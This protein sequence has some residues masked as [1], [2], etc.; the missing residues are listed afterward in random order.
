MRRI[1]SI[2]DLADGIL[3]HRE[4]MRSEQMRFGDVAPLNRLALAKAISLAESTRPDDQQAAQT[5]LELLL[6]HTGAARRIGITGVPGVGK[7]TFIEALGMILIERG[8]SLATLA[9]DPS[10]TRSGGSILGDKTR[11]TQLSRAPQAFIRPSPTSGSLGGVARRTREA[12]L[13]CEAAGFDVII[14]ETV[15]VG[16]SE[17]AVASMVDCFLMLMLPNAGDE[18][19]GMKRGIMELADAFIINKADLNKQAA[20]RAASQIRNAVHLSLPKYHDWQPPV[21][22]TSALLANANTSTRAG[23]EVVWQ[24]CE[25]F[26]ANAD[27]IHD[28]R[29]KQAVRWMRE[30]VDEGLRIML[31]QNADVAALWD[32]AEA[33]V[34]AQKRTPNSAADEILRAFRG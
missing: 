28:I 22:L 27:R 31:A 23:L 7:S 29:R 11:M 32:N 3:R 2:H 24:Q 20:E 4:Q 18:L 30:A 17:T 14:V 21:L 10:S 12:M 19:Q 15:G 6:P 13:L 5:L 26:F 25:D 8:L 9:I 33:E 34:L 1:S 16:Q